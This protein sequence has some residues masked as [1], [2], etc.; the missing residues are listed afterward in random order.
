MPEPRMNPMFAV[1]GTFVHSSDKEPLIT[2]QNHCLGVANGKILFLQKCDANLQTTLRQHNISAENVIYLQEWQF[3]VPGFVDTHIH[4]S[5]YPNCG[6]GIGEGLLSWLQK[7]TFPVEAKFAD[8]EFATD[9]YSRVISRVIKNGTTTACYFATIDTDATLRLCDIVDNA[10]QRALVGKVNMDQNSPEFYKEET[11]QS[12]QNTIRFVKEVANRKYKLV[13]PCITPRFAVTCG[14]DLMKQLGQLA[15]T[16]HLHVQTHICETKDECSLVQKLFPESTSYTDVY[17]QA[18][19]LTRKTILAHGIYLSKEERKII[20]SRQSGISHCPN[21]NLTIRSG[22][23]DVKACFE[24]NIAVGLGTDISGGYSPSILDAMRT[25]IS[26]S[27]TIALQ[28]GTDYTPLDYKDVFRMATLGGAKVLDMDEVIGNFE[29]GK[30]FDAL[31]IDPK[32]AGS[33]IDVFEND[34]VEDVIQKFVFLGDDRNILNVFVAGRDLSEK[35]FVEPL[36]I[37]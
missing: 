13:K 21:S 22:L 5:Q 29:V 3:M 4:A 15:Q 36:I 27:N 31:I 14:M 16:H 8:L 11:T 20:K 1:V 23:L 18:G 35:P 6:K 7:Y 37:S 32:A 24:D 33:V 17:E 28:Q 30:E 9:T 2:L 26:T 19:L 25:A 34:T 12:Y 10:G